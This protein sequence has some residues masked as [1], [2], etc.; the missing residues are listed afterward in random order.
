MFNL[1]RMDV[2]RMFHSIS[3]WVILIFT[4][5]LAVFFI[6]MTDM[7][8]Q[9][10]ADDQQYARQMEAEYEDNTDTQLGIYSDTNPQWV[11]GDI[12]AAELA[13]AGIKSGLLTL[14]CIIFAALFMSA[15]QKNGYIKNIAGQLPNRG[16]LA[17]SKMTAAALQVFLMM[18]VF[19]AVITLSAMILWGDRVCIRVSADLF[20]FLGVQ[21][22]LNL[23]FVA[24]IQLL[25]VLTRSSAFSMTAGILMIM[26]LTVPFYSA[27]NRVVLH[28]RPE[29]NFD[30]SRYMLEQ[31][32]VQTGLGSTG[33]I[34]ARGCAV[35]CG[36]LLMS[37]L[38][39]ILIVKKRDVR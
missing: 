20:A 18:A 11:S 12:D 23:G 13:G 25:C 19:A 21:Y 5:G 29:W 1:I 8:L 34:L 33:D 36:V 28:F 10:I 39:A 7:D 38:L 16:V 2:Y 22:L 17:L 14:L 35:G 4:A 32:I 30:I 3:T 26:G 31:N 15:E 6:M 37:T 9:A 24:L 27:F